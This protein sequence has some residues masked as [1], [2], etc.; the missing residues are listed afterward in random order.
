VRI[1]LRKRQTLA[2]YRSICTA[3]RSSDNYVVVFYSNEIFSAQ[4]CV[5]QVFASIKFNNAAAIFTSL[6]N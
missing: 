2:E 3:S 4:G 6:I 1:G 5:Q